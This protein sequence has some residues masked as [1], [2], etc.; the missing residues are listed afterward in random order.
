M[1]PAC[2]RPACGAYIGEAEDGEF[3]LYSDAVKLLGEVSRRTLE[4]ARL[5]LAIKN[6]TLAA[7]VAE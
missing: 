2:S 4:I 6:I 1:D 5:K 3:V 7:E